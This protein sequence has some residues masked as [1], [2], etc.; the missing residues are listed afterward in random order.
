[1]T[2]VNMGDEVIKTDLPAD[3]VADLQQPA[4]QAEPQVEK[5]KVE[6]AP[7]STVNPEKTENPAEAK[8]DESAAK[9]SKVEEQSKDSQGRYT[10]KPKPIATLLQKKHDLEVENA[11]LK[12][13]LEET[14]RQ[15]ASPQA[16]ADVK[17]L[18][19]RYGIDETLLQEIVDTTRAG[20]KPELPKEVQDLLADHQ[21]RKQ[22]QEEETHFNADYDSLVRTFDS[23]PLKD[24]SVKDK[25]L[26]LAYS[27]ELAPDGVPY[28]QKPLH[29]LY[30]K[31]VK[32]EIEPGKPSAE[33]SQGGTQATKVLDFEEIHN[34]DA[35]L[36]EFA[37]TA[38]PEKWQAYV[39]WR[40]AKQGDTPIIRKSI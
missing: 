13:K 6:P 4:E 10:A 2:E 17:Q 30:F 3:A 12:Q 34:D 23:E 24:Q 16:T 27:T 32:P 18:A 29:E 33:S 28:Y 40:D 26:A 7:E 9:T 19:E 25:V 11:E 1:M 37:R 21:K 20:M 8:A 14:S 39:K 22:E 36:E 35:K 5:P 15:P 31:F 38:S